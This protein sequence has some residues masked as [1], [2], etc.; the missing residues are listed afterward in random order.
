MKSRH[1]SV[2]VD[3]MLDQLLQEENEKKLEED[4]EALIFQRSRAIRRIQD[5]DF[6]DDF[7]DLIFFGNLRI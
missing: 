4:D 5:E 3:A 6:N 1:A 7:E 2:S